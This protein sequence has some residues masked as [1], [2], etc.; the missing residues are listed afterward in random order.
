MTFPV[1]RYSHTSGLS[2]E[3]EGPS[4][5]QDAGDV[6]RALCTSTPHSVGAP[7]AGGVLRVLLRSELLCC[8]SVKSLMDPCWSRVLSWSA[9]GRPS[10]GQES[11]RHA[12]F[13]LLCSWSE[14]IS[15]SEPSPPCL[16]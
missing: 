4:Q 10:G 9:L 6:G 16:R 7:R 8:V 15:F 3:W 13:S 11:R 1:C 2:V 12:A 14:S 5:S